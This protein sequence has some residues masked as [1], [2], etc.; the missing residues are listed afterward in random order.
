M[1]IT[2]CVLYNP[3]WYCCKHHNVC[4]EITFGIA[5][6]IT[7]CTVK[8]PLVLLQTLQ[9][10]LYDHP[11]YCCRHHNVYYTITLGTAANITMCAV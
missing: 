3:S 7:M 1:H 11:W 8:L 9:C 6:N 4:C 10:M 5:A 2:K